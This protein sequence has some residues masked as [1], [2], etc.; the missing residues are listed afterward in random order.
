GGSIHGGCRKTGRWS[1]GLDRGNLL[2]TRSIEA[3]NL[4]C[5]DRSRLDIDHANLVIVRVGHIQALSSH[6]Q[7]A[8]LIEAG[9]FVPAAGLAV[10]GEGLD[11]E[12][13]GVAELDLVVVG[14]GDEE[15]AS[16]VG[17]DGGRKQGRGTETG[18]VAPGIT[19]WSSHRSG[20][21]R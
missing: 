14:I 12:S 7:T 15:L 11:C 18:R 1:V 17:Q 9:R 6:A 19:P 16:A 20:R 4:E 3:G 5:P 8:G 13:V 10:A 2:R 21:A